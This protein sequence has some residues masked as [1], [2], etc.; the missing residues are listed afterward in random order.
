VLPKWQLRQLV[1][2]GGG[3]VQLTASATALV[4]PGE[5]V[6]VV[7]RDQA[8][9]LI[10]SG[11]WRIAAAT[12][13]AKL[14]TINA[15]SGAG[16]FIA[17]P[18]AVG[19]TVTVGFLLAGQ[20]ERYIA[21]NVLKSTEFVGPTLTPATTFVYSPTEPVPDP[22]PE[23]VVTNPTTPTAPVVGTFR[24]DSTSGSDTDANANNIFW[25]HT[26]TRTINYV[27]VLVANNVQAGATAAETHTVSYGGVAMQPRG[28][29]AVSST[30]ANPPQGVQSI[31]VT[32]NNPAGASAAPAIAAQAFAFENASLTQNSPVVVAGAAAVQS[33]AVTTSS[34]TGAIVV[35][36]VAARATV[37]PVSSSGETMVAQ[38]LGGTNMAATFADQLGGSSRISS[39]SWTTAVDHAAALAVAILPAT[40]A[41]TEFGVQAASTFAPVAMPL[42]DYVDPTGTVWAE[43]WADDFL[44][45]VAAGESNWNPGA[46]G[47]LP[48]AN[49]YR[50][51][52]KM[53]ERPISTTSKYGRYD[54]A[55]TTWV[56]GG[57]LR[58]NVHSEVVPETGTMTPLGGTFIPVISTYFSK[59][60]REQF[61][62]RVTNKVNNGVLLG[63]VWQNINSNNWPEFGEYDF[64][65][66]GFSGR[67]QGNF[68]PSTIKTRPDVPL[69]HDGSLDTHVA[70]TTAVARTFDEFVTVTRQWEPTATAGVSRLRWWV[71]DEL[72]MDRTVG[73]GDYE[74]VF[75]FQCGDNATQGNPAT[76]PDPATKAEVQIDWVKMWVHP[77]GQPTVAPAN[78]AVVA[79]PTANLPAPGG[80]TWTLDGTENF[81]TL[82]AMGEF[83][84]KYPSFSHYKRFMDTNNGPGIYD[85]DILSV[86]ANSPG[87]NGNVLDYYLHTGPT[88]N[89]T[90]PVTAPRVAAPIWKNY[91]PYTYGRFAVR[92]RC[93]DNLPKYK[94]AFL[95]WPSSDVWNDGEIDW[96]EVSELTFGTKPSPANAVP[97][98]FTGTNMTFV[99]ATRA[100]AATDMQNWH[101]AVTEWSPGLLVW[102][103]DGVEVARATGSAVPTVPMRWTLQAETSIPQQLPDPATSGHLEVDWAVAWKFTP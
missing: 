100:F 50:A 18:S 69:P 73:V 5:V 94:I 25:T 10:P 48:V 103:W 65:E 37:S 51:K 83:E 38:R 27:A 52:M 1:A 89:G 58:I 39:A 9:N 54:S 82:A 35:S 92:L 77:Q 95:H 12:N 99:P 79:M 75:M 84:A 22:V 19:T 29:R 67:I 17:P 93:R 86:K 36:V 32:L 59:F 78:P 64:P 55:R 76:I 90:T 2:S 30:S 53:Y 97:G 14:P 6:T 13:G 61:R 81:D 70:Y 46:G 24:V 11:T 7:A 56:E 57:Y 40:G 4:E 80:G 101:V 23:L 20:T 26:P 3:A 72:I 91:R 60:T 41:T 16:V 31:S 44:T 43:L 71:G 21:V 45:P 28:S 98:T 102:L 96:P 49:P 63:G 8:G 88:F 74:M 62:Y 15:T 34:V 85:P 68:H 33:L 47:T 42:G 87:A 66:S